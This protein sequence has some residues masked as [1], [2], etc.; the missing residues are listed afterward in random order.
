[1]LAENIITG[2]FPDANIIELPV[3]NVL[4]R[5]MEIHSPENLEC[6]DPLTGQS[7]FFHSA[8]WEKVLAETYG[9]TPACF[10][11]NQSGKPVAALSAMEVDSWLTGRRGISLPF[12]D[13]CEPFGA[14]RKSFR[15][16]FEETV[17]FG[18][19]RGW[20]SFELRGGR[21]FFNDVPSSLS[22]Y[23]HSLK[24]AGD[25]QHLFSK[26]ESSVRR[27]IRRAEKE[28]IT[29]EISQDF[30]AVKNF[31]SL[32]CQT[33]RRHG[34]PPQPFSFFQNIHRRV[35]SQNAG[36]VVLA[37]FHKK[38]VAGA[39]YF[40]LGG[41]AIYKF[42]AS[43]KMFQHLRANNLVMWRAIQWF[44][45]R[46]VKKLDFG[47]TSIANEGLRRFK[48]GW[49]A[50]ERKIEYFK[51]DLRKNRFITGYDETSGWHNRI[52]RALPGFASRAIGK[53]LYRHWA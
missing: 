8:A 14:D 33:R 52:F 15:K 20:K 18:K 31:Y 47:K 5:K 7:S 2:I 28:K 6:D 34:L 4:A 51:F 53:A 41:R 13:E 21:K 35:L 39:V 32:H 42:G 36:I 23:G 26:L 16:V 12:T 43:D 17:E 38:P 37:F 3:K 24:L 9:Y 40:Y 44:L 22:F 10:S 50:E 11:A 48:S 49:G 19:S 45:R 27:A 29:V 25:E 1:M 30:N 46:D